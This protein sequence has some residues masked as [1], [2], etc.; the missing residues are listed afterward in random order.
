VAFRLLW[1][2]IFAAFEHLRDGLAWPALIVAF[3]LGWRSFRFWWLLVLVIF[4]AGAANHIYAYATGETKIA[5]A[6]GNFPF[7]LLVF[8]MLSAIGY[9]AGWTLR[10][11]RMPPS[12]E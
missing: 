9:I 3:L 11:R 6:M 7:E 10:R 8:A 1:L 12:G 4:L 2:I 5:G